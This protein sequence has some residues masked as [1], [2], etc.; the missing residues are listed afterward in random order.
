MPENNDTEEDEFIVRLDEEQE[1]TLWEIVG[2][3][4]FRA[5]IQGFKGGACFM[6][7]GAP[8]GAVAGFFYGAIRGLHKYCADKKLRSGVEK[9]QEASEVSTQSEAES[10]VKPKLKPK[11]KFVDQPDP[12][13]QSQTDVAPDLSQPQVTAST[14]VAPPTKV[15]LPA[16][17]PPLTKPKPKV[18][19]KPDLSH[20]SKHKPNKESSKFFADK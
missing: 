20:R 4:A 13:A 15:A 12:E 11:P 10:K 16:K 3:L 9:E 14:K 8:F 2:P 6:G 1:K 5:T 18:K 7:I 17:V 19:P